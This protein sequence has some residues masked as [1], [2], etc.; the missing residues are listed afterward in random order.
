MAVRPFRPF[1]TFLTFLTFLPFL[2]FLP[3]LTLP[4]A[5]S[6]A[7]RFLTFPAAAPDKR[8]G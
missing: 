4:S 7:A 8:S 5:T 1:L 2:P 3:F 6:P